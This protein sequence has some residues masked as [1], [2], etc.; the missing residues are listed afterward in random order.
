MQAVDYLFLGYRLTGSLDS[1]ETKRYDV[2]LKGDGN[3]YGT[4]TT[5]K[6]EK[7]RAVVIDKV[8]PLIS[9]L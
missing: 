8:W 9:H 6:R 2:V 1:K 4:L 5:R 7:H 3:A